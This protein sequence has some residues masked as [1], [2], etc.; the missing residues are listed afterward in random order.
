MLFFLVCLLLYCNIFN[1]TGKP[2]TLIIITSSGSVILMTTVAEILQ[3]QIFNSVN[4]TKQPSNIQLLLRYTG[5]NSISQTRLWVLLFFQT[6]RKLYVQLNYAVYFAK[7][8]SQKF[9]EKQTC[10]C[11]NDSTSAPIMILLTAKVFSWLWLT[12]GQLW[13]FSVIW[14]SQSVYM[15]L[16]HP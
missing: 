15:H 1:L 16:L 12:R 8:P 14:K 13:Y 5:W 4:Q 6:W 9:R 11:K 2:I 7:V 10:C 3:G